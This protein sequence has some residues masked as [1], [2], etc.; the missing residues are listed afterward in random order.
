MR[1]SLTLGISVLLFAFAILGVLLGVGVFFTLGV[2]ADTCSISFLSFEL[3]TVLLSEV[4]VVMLT[5][6][7]PAFSESRCLL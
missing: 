5:K 1:C 2:C 6:V 7:F 4:T 3:K